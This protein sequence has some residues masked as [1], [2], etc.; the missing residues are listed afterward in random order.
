MNEQSGVNFRISSIQYVKDMLLTDWHFT[1][2]IRLGLGLLIVWHAIQRP[3]V[4]SGILATILLFQA[5]TN[6]GCCGASGCA[7]TSK[8]KHNSKTKDVDYEEVK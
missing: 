7:V 3:D 8:Q 4:L 2:W 6:T 5:F 1:R